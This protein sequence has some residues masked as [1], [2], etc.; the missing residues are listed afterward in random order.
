[1]TPLSFLW[2]PTVT[3]ASWNDCPTSLLSRSQLT[4]HYLKEALLD[5][6]NQNLPAVT[7]SLFDSFIFIVT[8]LAELISK[9]NYIVNEIILF[10][11]FYVYCLV[12][13]NSLQPHGHR[14]LQA[15][16]LEWI[17]GIEARSPTLEADS[18][19]AEPQGLPVNLL[20]LTCTAL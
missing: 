1:M 17:P 11:C 5:C 18:L 16:I 6:F 12:M 4:S 13:S 15:R 20:P 14:I 10:I 3:A 9:W 2:V 19:P 7:Y 8:A